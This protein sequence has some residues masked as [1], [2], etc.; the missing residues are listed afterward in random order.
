MD[1]LRSSYPALA[2]LTYLNNCS[3]GLFSQQLLDFRRTLD[4]NFMH[5]GSNFRA[6]VYQAMKGIKETIADAFGANADQL[7]LIPSCSHGINMVLEALADGQK[8]LHLQ[9]DY[10]SIIW[11]FQSRSFNCV[12]VRNKDYSEASLCEYIEQEKADILAVSAVQYSNGEIIAPENFQNIKE[13]F[14]DL[15]IMVD[16]TQFF[17]TAPLNFKESG[18]DLF[19]ASTFKWMCAGYGNGAMF[20][21]DQLKEVLQSK[22]RGYNTFKNPRKEGQPTIGEYFEPGHQ[23][24][25]AFKSL[26]FQVQQLNELGFD[27]IQAQIKKIKTY[28][29][30]EISTKTKFDVQTSVN[31]LLESG[32]L[33]IDAPKS[34]VKFL[35][36]NKIVCSFNRGLRL[37]IHFYN[38]EADVDHL[39]STIQLF[40]H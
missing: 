30:E 3:S 24:L 36:Q 39:V 21:S 40:K 4:Q 31:P 26:Q 27:Q 38:N 5:N 25:L 10:P 6:G 34:L 22:T 20:I 14:P 9:N 1:H 23:D 15:L 13:Q 8:V 37:G 2:D 33:S 28:A 35:N 29:R 32:I 12:T 16:A 18:I 7:A 17:G 19:A 11:P